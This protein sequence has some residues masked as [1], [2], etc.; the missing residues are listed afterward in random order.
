MILILRWFINSLSLLLVAYIMPG[1]EIN[2]FFTALIAV[3]FLAI[4][5][6]LIR[7]ILLLLTLPINILTLGI[8]T[9]FINALMLWFVASF[10][11]GFYITN[12][13]TAFWAA[14]IYWIITI[15]TNALLF[16]SKDK[17]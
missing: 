13:M 9:L 8:F 3:F 12:Y 16:D 2:N 17:E 1:V 15:L 4:V 5:N 14:I 10:T 11:N 6:A 7:P